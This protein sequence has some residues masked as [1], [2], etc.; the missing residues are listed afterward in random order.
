MLDSHWADDKADT[1]LRRT[2]HMC[3]ELCLEQAAKDGIAFFRYR[4][5]VESLDAWSASRLLSL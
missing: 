4:V 3:C 5:E 2:E 1:S